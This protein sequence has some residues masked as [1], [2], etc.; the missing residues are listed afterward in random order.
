[1]IVGNVNFMK[2]RSEIAKLLCK[3]QKMMDKN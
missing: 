1:M 3:K 2:I